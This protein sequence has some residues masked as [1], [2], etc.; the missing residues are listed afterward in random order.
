[1]QKTLFPFLFALLLG[2]CVSLTTANQEP[3]AYLVL[4]PQFLE[5]RMVQ[6]V[7]APYTAVSV[8]HL[9]LKLFRL[10]GDQEIPVLDGT[11]PKQVDIPKANLEKPILIEKLLMNTTYRVRA[12]AYQDEGTS[13]LISL[14]A[15]STVDVR[16]ESGDRPT[17]ATLTVQLKDI[18]F[19]GQATTSLNIA[20]GS[21]LPDGTPSIV[22]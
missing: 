15:S 17:M 16:L 9:M 21:V 18:T 12:Y 11:T 6:T 8:N 2:G 19:N 5:G 14:D 3:S 7:V 4:Q 20:S 13:N 10:E 1:M 22:F